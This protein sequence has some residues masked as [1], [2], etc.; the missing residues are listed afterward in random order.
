MDVSTIQI[1]EAFEEFGFWMV[2]TALKELQSSDVKRAQV[3][4]FIGESKLSA[5]KPFIS[6]IG[7][8]AGQTLRVQIK[9]ARSKV[10][11]IVIQREGQLYKYRL[12][13][14]NI[15]SPLPNAVLGIRPRIAGMRSLA[16]FWSIL[17]P[18]VADSRRALVAAAI[19]MM[20]TDPQW[21]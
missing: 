11:F 5:G 19:A 17:A 21:Y 8:A 10:F 6:G 1:I 4:L 20:A 14:G 16:A 7:Q 12:R 13:R 18:T 9:G 2:Y 3:Q 15:M